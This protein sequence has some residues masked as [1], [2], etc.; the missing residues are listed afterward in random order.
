MALATPADVANLTGVSVGEAAIVQAEAVIEMATG[1]SAALLAQVSVADTRWVL[2]AV[3][4][5]SA[6]MA[7]HP[8]TFAA[9]DVAAFSQLDQSVTFREGRDSGYLAPMARRA[10][11]RCSW[12]GTRSVSVGSAFQRTSTADDT[13][14]AAL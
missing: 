14:W 1:R 4:Y 7:S 5:Q 13:G 12:S 6:W 2:L 10:L 9:M 11:R 8:E 3:A